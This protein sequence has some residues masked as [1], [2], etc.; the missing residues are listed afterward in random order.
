[1]IPAGFGCVDHAFEDGRHARWPPFP[2]FV[3]YLNRFIFSRKHAKAWQFSPCWKFQPREL[4]F[5]AED[6]K[7]T[8]A[9]VETINIK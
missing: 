6:W 4:S 7:D 3:P 1:M 2:W 9:F 5:V 8:K